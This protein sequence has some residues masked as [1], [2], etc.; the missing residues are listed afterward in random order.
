[1][2]RESDLRR[3]S[4]QKSSKEAWFMAD[5]VIVGGGVAA[6]QA[7]EQAQV[8]AQIDAEVDTL[9]DDAASFAYRDTQGGKGRRGRSKFSLAASYLPITINGQRIME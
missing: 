6:T 5:H 7:A 4:T 9:C 3:N 1:M 2:V 8:G